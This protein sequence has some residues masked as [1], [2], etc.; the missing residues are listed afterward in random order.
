M[1]V[2]SATKKRLMDLSFSEDWAHKLADDRKWNDIKELWPVQ[3]Y[4]AVILAK[5][6]N[7]PKYATWRQKMI[8]GVMAKWVLMNQLSVKFDA[9]NKNIILLGFM[10]KEIA[11]YPK[12]GSAVFLGHNSYRGLGADFKDSKGGTAQALKWFRLRF[13]PISTNL[14]PVGLP[15]DI[16][17]WQMDLLNLLFPGTGKSGEGLQEL[18]QLMLKMKEMES[19]N[20]AQSINRANITDMFYDNQLKHLYD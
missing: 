6:G 13:S 16:Q 11:Y 3:F 9:R 12:T 2:K 7:D 15:A 17:E 4:N 19:I 14:G 10:D 8:E 1:V 18:Y 20:I 5:K